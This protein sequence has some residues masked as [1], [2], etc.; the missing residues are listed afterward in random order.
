MGMVGADGPEERTVTMT[1]VVSVRTLLLFLAF[2]FWTLS[3]SESARGMPQLSE[4]VE[5]A[6]LTVEPDLQA[7]SQRLEGSPAIGFFTK[8]D[9]KHQFELLLDD[10]EALHKEGRAKGVDANV[11]KER[12]N[13]IL[14]RIL[15]LIE[16]SDPALYSELSSAEE[17]IWL[18]LKSGELLK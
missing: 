9:L 4:P 6:M 16:D 14:V 3:F 5:Q 2:G 1:L 17:A 18:A 10:I 15:N 12:F 11:L 8:L 13:Q 7:L